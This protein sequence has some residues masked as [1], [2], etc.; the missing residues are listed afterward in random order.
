MEVDNVSD[1]N[2]RVPS[3]NEATANDL[4]IPGGYTSGG[5]T[6]TIPLDRTHVTRIDI[7]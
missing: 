4:W 5:V 3:G 6:D 7:N 1:L 2:I